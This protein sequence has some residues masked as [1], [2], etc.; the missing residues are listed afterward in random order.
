MKNFLIGA[1]I[2]VALLAGL[3]GLALGGFAMKTMFENQAVSAVSQ[4]VETDLTDVAGVTPSEG[5]T[6]A[7]LK[8]ELAG[9]NTK[10]IWETGKIQAGARKDFDGT[11]DS[12]GGAV[13][14][15]PETKTLKALE[16]VILIESFNGYGSTDERA[17]GGLV[18]T[19]LGKGVAPPTGYDPWFNWVDHPQA[20]F[21]ATEFVER[22][23]TTEAGYANAPEGWTHLI[24]GTFDLNGTQETLAIPAVVSFNG[25]AVT[26][27]TAFTISREAY[28]VVPENPLPLTEVDD[29][30]L[31]TASVTATPDAGL[32]V[33][34]LAKMIGDQGT[35]IGAQQKT[36]AELQ[37]QLALLTESLT[38]LERTVAKGVG[39]AAPAVDVASLP[40]TYTDQIQYPDKTPIEFE[41][42][43][44]PGGDGVDPFYMGKHEVT[45]EMFYN[46][47]YGSDIDANE[48]AQLQSKNARPSPLY[49]DCNQLKLGL[50][51][52]PAL[53]MSRTTA[54]AFAKWVS[55][56]TGKSYRVPTDAEW[57]H[58]L[59]LGGGMP[60]TREELFEQAVFI[61]NAEIQFDP[62][63]LELTDI[64]GTK[65]PNALG[66]HDM[67]GNA[68]EWVVDTGADRIVRGGHFMLSADEWTPAWKAVENQ[69]EWN[70]TYPQLPVSKFW[71]RDHYYQGMRLVADVQ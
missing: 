4:D 11:W 33:D 62:P 46:W 10:L 52:R 7:E 17:P 5:D 14:Y 22:T 45:W 59:K 8:H 24:K 67:I 61:D 55:E 63:F 2:V 64:V 42:V 34:G 51:K 6:V 16:V 36:I 12:L 69:A 28:G 37:T 41:M 21:A 27:D 53:S 70:E 13:V 38:K 56:Q 48:Y 31:L 20:V 50:G 60:N 9:G 26:I 49:E 30:V 35:L 39:P 43:L 57:M 71:Y 18:N 44:V 25:D 3:G 47:A 66:I 29:E 15:D 40:K 58:A 68:S 32:V 1:V 19:V 54:E 65:K 23:D